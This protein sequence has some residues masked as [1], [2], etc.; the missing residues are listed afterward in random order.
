MKVVAEDTNIRIS[1]IDV[2]GTT[3]PNSYLITCL[4]T[5]VSVLV[6]VPAKAEMVFD[7]TKNTVLKYYCGHTIVT[8]EPVD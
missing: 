5:G 4:Q 6:D 2:G 3:R 8:N 7:Q 1:K